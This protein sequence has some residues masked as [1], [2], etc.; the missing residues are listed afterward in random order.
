MSQPCGDADFRV[1]REKSAMPN[2]LFFNE[3]V[4]TSTHFCNQCGSPA[5]NTAIFVD[6]GQIVWKKKVC[7]RC[8]EK[9]HEEYMKRRAETESLE[10]LAAQEKE[11]QIAE[12]MANPTV[13]V[14]N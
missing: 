3:I 14:N 11:K 13:A 7:D 12:A 2:G 4:S 1:D 10:K 8:S 9:M 6:A 5:Q